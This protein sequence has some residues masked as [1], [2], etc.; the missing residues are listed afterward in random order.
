MTVCD[1]FFSYSN[2]FFFTLFL[3]FLFSNTNGDSSFRPIN[4]V[5][6]LFFTIK[7]KTF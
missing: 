1:F 2:T 6:F 5:F 7:K 4:I 3:T